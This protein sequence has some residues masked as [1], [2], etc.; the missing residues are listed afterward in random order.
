M[1]DWFSLYL[2]IIKLGA[3]SQMII[4][5]RLSVLQRG[6]PRAQREAARMVSEKA[7]A[8]ATAIFA[9]NLALASGKAPVAAL[10]STVKSYRKKVIANRRRLK[11]RAK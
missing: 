5:Q 11:R 6:G 7:L 9:L 1:K 8:A 4:L 10:E 3:E 2:D